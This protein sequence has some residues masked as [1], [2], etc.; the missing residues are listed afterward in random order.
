MIMF[1]AVS[2]SGRY[3]HH[4]MKQKLTGDSA[5]RNSS[6]PKGQTKDEK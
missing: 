6:L 2:G 1:T 3:T 4:A 5:E